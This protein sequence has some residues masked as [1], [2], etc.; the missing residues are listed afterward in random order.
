[1]V[2]PAV[3]QNIYSAA[4]GGG[5]RCG[6]ALAFAGRRG[7]AG[8]ALRCGVAAFAA[9]GVVPV[10]SGG[11]GGGGSAFMM[12]TGGIDAADGK[13]TFGPGT[14]IPAADEAAGAEAS[15]GGDEDRAI[16]DSAAVG[17]FAA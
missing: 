3:P 1:M 10:V 7:G 5:A 2:R 6:S 12:L 4:G 8:G 14:L 9:G 15:E 13:N 11:V 17:Q 16:G